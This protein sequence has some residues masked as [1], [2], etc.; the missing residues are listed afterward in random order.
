MKDRYLCSDFLTPYTK[1][2]YQPFPKTTNF[3]LSQTEKF[4]DTNFTFDENGGKV[5]KMGGKHCGKRRN[6]S[7]RAIS[8]FP[9]E[10]S[11]VLYCRHI[12]AEICQAMGGNSFFQ[13]RAQFYDAIKI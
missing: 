13:N 1:Q 2:M 11:N 10:F 5:L 9:T 6:C 8:P 4:E 3:R 7:L 12:L